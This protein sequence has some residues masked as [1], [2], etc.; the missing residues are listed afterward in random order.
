MKIILATDINGGIGYKNKLPWHSTEELNFFKQKTL[1]GNLIMGKR[2]YDNIPKLEYRTIHVVTNKS[3]IHQFMVSPDTTDWWICGGKFVYDTVL[4]DYPQFIS[5]IEISIMKNSAERCDTFIDIKT[6]LKN[7]SVIQYKEFIDFH[8]YTLVF[9][10]NEE[11]GYLN[12]LKNVLNSNDTE[13]QT[14]NSLTK[15]LFCKHLEF[16]LENGFPLLTTKKMFWKGI[17]SEFLFFIN[18]YIDT[19]WLEEKKCNI[20]KPNT[21]R[22]FLDTLNMTDVEE[23]I[24]GP[25]YG[26]QWRYFNAK[27]NKKT[28]QPLESGIDQLAKLISELKNNPNSRRHLMTTFNP[29]QVDE[30][31]LYPCHSLITQFYV[32]S[33]GYLNMFCYNRSSDLFLGLPFNI[34][35]SALL[36]EMIAKICNMKPKMLHISLGDCH[37]YNVH[38]S[39]CEEQLNPYRIPWKLPLLNIKKDNLTLDTIKQL[40]IDD[41][42]L[43]NYKSYSILKATMIP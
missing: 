40:N 29:N 10:K 37:I 12:L 32:D 2:T 15:S 4:K 39:I 28:G 1:N 43:I 25:M 31:V 14:R 19:K 8:Q 5:S 22:A 30:G 33:S 34:A 6:L 17:V 42:Q 38:K 21:S 13:R 16:N 20:W 27:W 23:G 35:S 9:S 3:D 18:G 26:Y 24:M 36:L 7:W 11:H 41:F